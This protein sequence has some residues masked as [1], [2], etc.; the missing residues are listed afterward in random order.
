MK[1]VDRAIQPADRLSPLLNGGYRE[2]A[3]CG[4]WLTLVLLVLLI[5]IVFQQHL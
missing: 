2:P 4:V 3:S 5:L 1:S